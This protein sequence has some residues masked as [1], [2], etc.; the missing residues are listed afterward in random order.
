[1]LRSF[2]DNILAP[3]CMAL[4]ASRGPCAAAQTSDERGAYQLHMTPSSPSSEHEARHQQTPLGEC[5]GAPAFVV[6]SRGGNEVIALSC[7]EE[8][9]EFAARLRDF[10]EGLA[11]PVRLRPVGS[12]TEHAWVLDMK[13]KR[14]V[15]EA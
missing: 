5:G 11:S 3:A 8:A 13:L 1:M 15:V 4:R 12:S 14:W 9:E 10:S 6:C 2:D 7:W